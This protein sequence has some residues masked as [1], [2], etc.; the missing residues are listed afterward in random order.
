MASGNTLFALYPKGHSPT[1]TLGATFDTIS[2]ASTPASITEVL[3]FDGAAQDEHAEWNVTVPSQYAGGGFNVVIKYAMSGTDADAVQ[4]EVRMLKLGD[5]ADLDTDLG[6]DTQ[7]ATDITD[8]PTGTANAMMVTSAGAV[9][10]SNAGSPSAGDHMR[11]RITRDYDHASNTDD[12][13]LVAVYI[14]ET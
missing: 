8:T 5:T 13:Q 10:H 9:T 14:T 4:F 7:T 11:I 3:D 12:A 2:D 1:V 6:M